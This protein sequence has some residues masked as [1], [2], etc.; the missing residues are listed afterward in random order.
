MLDAT[1]CNSC[2][3]LDPLLCDLLQSQYLCLSLS[4][5]FRFSPEI[6]K[7]DKSFNSVYAVTSGADRNEAI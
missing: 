1:E 3:S 7:K 4:Y 6:K 2:F 5:K